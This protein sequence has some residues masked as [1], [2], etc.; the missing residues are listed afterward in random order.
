[1][2][3]DYINQWEATEI[4]HTVWNQYRFPDNIVIETS[5]ELGTEVKFDTR[6]HK[7]YF[8]DEAVEDI[9]QPEGIEK[10]RRWV[11]EKIYEDCKKEDWKSVDIFRILAWKTGKINYNKVPKNEPKGIF[12]FYDKNWEE[13]EKDD[14]FVSF[15]IP[16]QQKV[17][18][19]KF[20]PVSKKIKD[21]R[22][23]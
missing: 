12:D 14:C 11:E 20:E 22:R 6:Y 1:M 8:K 13:S 7:S 21:I 9:I 17:E 10:T 23:I 18:W 16:Y 3:I 2:Y 15:Q 19:N 4:K 5:S